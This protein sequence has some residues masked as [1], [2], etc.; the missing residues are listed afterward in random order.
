MVLDPGE[1]TQDVMDN[2]LDRVQLRT[3]G[4]LLRNPREVAFPHV[5]QIVD[6]LCIL[7]D[8][9]FVAMLLLQDQSQAWHVKVARKVWLA[10]F[11]G[12][13]ELKFAR[14]VGPGELLREHGIEL[15]KS[16]ILSVRQAS[17]I[18][19]R[20]VIDLDLVAQALRC[21]SRAMFSAFA[22]SLYS[23]QLSKSLKLDHYKLCL[24]ALRTIRRSAPPNC[25]SYRRAKE[26]CRLRSCYGTGQ[27]HDMP[28][29]PFM[30]VNTAIKLFG[31]AD[32][33]LC[34]SCRR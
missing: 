3:L 11:E 21:A 18:L 1:I 31:I 4:V 6:A 5:P 34:L 15:N 22:R 28:C 24:P 17:E 23:R 8:P 10:F 2:V 32:N 20:L 9:Q 13:I 14:I 16:H 33:L 27:A 19:V 12:A 30:Q 7:E 25:P 26:T 29:V